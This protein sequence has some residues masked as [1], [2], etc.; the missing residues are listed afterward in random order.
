MFLFLAQVGSSGYYLKHLDFKSNGKYI[1][2]PI[3]ST[4]SNWGIANLHKDPDILFFVAENKTTI[5]LEDVKKNE[6]YKIKTSKP[7][8][9]GYEYMYLDGN[10]TNT[11]FYNMYLNSR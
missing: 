4:L 7:W 3:K 6:N 9:D 1:G 5:R 10:G 11:Y 2:V 8:N